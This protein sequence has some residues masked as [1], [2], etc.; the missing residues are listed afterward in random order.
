[1]QIVPVVVDSSLR[2]DGNLVGHDLADQLFDELIIPNE[3]HYEAKRAKR[4]GWEDIPAEIQLGDLVGDFLVIPRGFALELKLALREAGKKVI[5]VDRRTWERGAPLKWRK[6]FTPRDHQP[7]AVAMMRK[8]EQGI[9]EAPTGSGK[10]MTVLYFLHEV[11]PQKILILVDKLDLQN[12][13]IKEI[14]NWFGGE[15]V[16]K[17]GDGDWIEGKRIAVA[18]FQSIR[19]A[20]N[21]GLI[22]E[23]DNFWRQYDAVIDDECH[24]T[25]ADTLQDIMERF[26]ARYRL[27]VSATPDRLDGRFEIVQNVLG[28]V[29][30]ANTEEELRAA[31]VLVRPTVNVIK[32]GFKFT[33]WGD[34]TSDDRGECDMPGCKLKH[35]H[36]HRNNY[37]KLK[38]AVVRDK[39][40]NLLVSSAVLAQTNGGTHHHLIVSDEIRHLDEIHKILSGSAM[41]AIKTNMP[42]IF[43][44]TGKVRGKKRAELIEEIKRL[45]ECIVLATVAKE[46]LDIPQ[47]DRIYLPFPSGNPKKVQQWLGRGT[48]IFEGKGDVIVTD[49]NDIDTPILRGQF[50]KRRWQC[51]ERLGLEV[52]V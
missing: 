18:T 17:I 23:D 36:S 31:G 9:Y 13:W 32:T 26:W 41:S 10:T 19:A 16:G 46:G 20:M 5:W 1:M 2:L 3:K 47:I 33:Y 34:H 27:G 14:G 11:A 38:T 28:E 50:M 40:R 30:Y 22:G 43:V 45:D 24:H 25:R 15:Y 51:Y 35:K 6:P 52:H 4:W 44:L 29:F 12:Q 49:F 42:Q 39:V 37:N 7:R 21:R 8:H 48:R